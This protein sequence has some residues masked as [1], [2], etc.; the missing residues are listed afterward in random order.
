MYPPNLVSFEHA[1]AQLGIAESELDDFIDSGDLSTRPYLGDV[2]LLAEEVAACAAKRAVSVS[3]PSQDR[4]IV[5]ETRITP[6]ARIARI[7]ELYASGVREVGARQ[8]SELLG[9]G[10]KSM[11]YLAREGRVN[12]EKR[13]RRNWYLVEYIETYAGLQNVW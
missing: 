9:I 8:A 6:D 11:S 1:A 2:Y 12:A 13:G 5:K 10:I 3:S 4:P 7:Q